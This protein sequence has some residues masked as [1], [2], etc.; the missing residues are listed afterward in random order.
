M[1]TS[2]LMRLT[3]IVWLLAFIGQSLAAS[4]VHCNMQMMASMSVESATTDSHMNHSRMNYAQMDHSEMDHSQM[5]HLNSEHGSHSDKIMQ[6]SIK[7]VPECCQI[8]ADCNEGNCSYVYLSLP[9]AQIESPLNQS[10]LLSL[11]TFAQIK[12]Q[13]SL[14][15]PPIFA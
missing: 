5:S 14:Y 10:K 13:S 7:L 9:V 11:S 4:V 6:D 8:S 15:R 1:N 12:R 3:A 2:T